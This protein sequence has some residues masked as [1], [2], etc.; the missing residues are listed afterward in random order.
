[1]R[2]LIVA[3]T[4]RRA[5]DDR[6]KLW[7]THAMQP[8]IRQLK[9]AGLTVE[10]RMLEGEPRRTLLQEAKR[11]KADSIFVGARGLGAVDRFLMGSVSMVVATRAPCTV[12][13]VR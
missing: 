5:D 1:M 8:V 6:A 12:E 9:A 11:W 2:L 4:A 7:Q 10:A 13:V 3:D